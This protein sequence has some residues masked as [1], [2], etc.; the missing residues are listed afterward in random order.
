M[1][2]RDVEILTGLSRKTI[3]F[4]EEKGLLSVDRSDNSYR[5]YDEGV[6]EQLKLIALLRQAGISLAD[7]QLW[8][9]G[10][11]SS[12][13]MLNKRLTE[14]R[15]AADI[16]MDQVRLCNQLLAGELQDLMGE[17]CKSSADDPDL[18]EVSD[19]P[20][21]LCLGLDIGTTTISAVVLDPAGGRSVGVY[22]IAGA[23]DIPADH[24]WEKMQ[25]PEKI[26]SRVVKLLDSLLR[27]FPGVKSVGITGQMHGILYVNQDGNALSPLYTWQD[28][29]AGMGDPSP[30][31]ILADRTG[32]TVSPG[33]G[34][35]T[36]FALMQ[37]G[38][39]PSGAA[40]ICTIMDYA[41]MKLTGRTD[42]VMHTSNAA[43]LGF[44]ITAENRFDT[45]AI[46]RAGMDP[47][48]LPPVTS[49]GI[50]PGTWNGI[51]VTAAIGD[52]QASFFGS[53][54]DPE[55]AALANFG[56]GSQ[57]SLMCRS[58]EGISTD[59]AMELRPFVDC[60]WLASG[61]ALC[62]GRAY[63]LM[64]RF[65]RQYVTACG[66]NPSEQY[67]IMNKLALQGIDSGKYLEVRT[68]FCGTRNDPGLRGSITGISE[69]LLTPEA[70]IAGILWGMAAELHD[71]FLKMP[72][73]HVHTLILSGNAVRKNPAL[74]KML[75]QVFGMEAYLPVHMEEAAFGAAMFSAISSGYAD[76]TV[77][78]CIRYSEIE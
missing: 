10:V 71:M 24:V 16:A 17:A 5:E 53:V 62:G 67:E 73:D 28:E 77:R 51:P 56:T 21:D 6:V 19:A 22:T 31:R 7:I 50:H 42:P 59:A 38:E 37:S 33:Y 29:R 44:W 2:I 8:Q 61:S 3:R 32:Y 46:R 4:Y 70:M 26:V 63:A 27:R 60:T 55:H 9:D 78:S 76:N 12:G 20:G 35:A 25:D 43:S 11:I 68:T 45:D 54:R 40:K 34:L 36:H 13:E 49:A 58:T 48:I 39:V 1:R 30:C 15:S 14:L 72:H 47:E 64:E 57:I 75:K 69:D 52:N 23:S 65:F 74:R 66:M 18:D 41:V